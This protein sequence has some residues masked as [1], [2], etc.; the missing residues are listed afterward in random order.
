MENQKFFK[1]N[2]IISKCLNFEKCRYNWD[3]INDSFLD[4]LWKFVNYIPVCPEVAIWL[5]TPRATIRIVQDWEK[6]ELIQPKTWANLT[7]KMHKFS[8]DFLKSQKE[9]DWFIMKS[10]SPSCWIKDIKVY[11]KKSNLCIW[12]IWK[13]LFVENI[14]DIFAKIPKEM[15]WRLKNFQLREEFLAKIFCLAEFREIKKNKKISELVDFQ[16]KNKYLFMLFSPK[17]QKDLWLLIANYD[18]NNLE[19][20]LEKFEKN[21]LELFLTQTKKWKMINVLLHIFWYFKKE[22]NEREK[23]FFLKSVNKYQSWVASLSSVTD[24][25]KMFAERFEKEYILN[26]SILNPFPEDLLDLLD[27]K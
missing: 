21:L 9:I 10:A 15:D 27:A 22:I 17:I 19:E 16:A 4:K 25:L 3:R 11:E 20:I 6:N 18:K 8:Q 12:R 13:W 14:D 1:P 5:W 24:L 26:Q 2:I 23:K 7:E